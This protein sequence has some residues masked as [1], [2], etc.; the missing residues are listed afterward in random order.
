MIELTYNWGVD[1]YDLG[2]GYGHI[3]IEVDDVYQA[4]ERIKA[5]GGK[6]LR[7]AGPITI[8]LFAY[9][10][11]DHCDYASNDTAAGTPDRHTISDSGCATDAEFFGVLPDHYVV[12]NWP[13][14]LN[15]L[16]DGAA[17]SKPE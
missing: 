5:K 14:V 7:D 10:D 3:A 11:I 12:G 1:H 4:T 8:D 16:V 6:I 15:S 13:T 9:C 2:N 17:R